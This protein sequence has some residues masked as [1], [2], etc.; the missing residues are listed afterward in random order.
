VILLFD[1]RPKAWFLAS[2][3][4]VWYTAKD[5]RGPYE[6]TKKVPKAVK[7]LAPNGNKKR[8]NVEG[9]PPRI[10]VATEPT[11]LI[12]VGGNPEYSPLGEVDLLTLT[13][14]D[15][16]VI[17]EMASQKHYVLLSGRWFASEKELEGPWN[18]VA[19]S[20]LPSAFAQI[21]ADSDRGH[22]LAH[23]P[24][25]V[26]AQEALLDN[27]IPQTA[28]IRRDD[29]SFNAEY[30]GSPKF[31][32]VEG[33]SIDYA[34][35]TPQA[36]FK[37]GDRY[38][39]CDQGVW[40]E[41]GSPTGPWSVATEVPKTLYDIPPSNPHHN[42]TYVKV[43][44]VTPQV[45]HVGYTPGYSGSYVYQGCVVYGTGWIYPGWYGSVYYP[46]HSTWGFNLNYSPWYGWGFG[47]SWSSG[48]LTVSVGWGGLMWGHPAWWGPWGWYPYYPPV[49]PPYFPGYRPPYYPG[50]YPPRYPGYR[51]P[52]AHLPARNPQPGTPAQLPSG[53][54]RP[55][56][57][58]ARDGNARRNAALPES[59]GLA[60]PAP[61][62]GRPDNVLVDRSGNIY[63]RTQGGGW[64]QRQGGS[65][66][67]TTGV[68]S[69]S[70]PATR[71]A[72]PGSAGG[73]N[74][75][76]SA[77]QRGANRSSVAPRPTPQPRAVPRR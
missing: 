17:V 47:I 75:D 32:H 62:P 42:V 26:Q 54:S 67:G 59:P 68:G 73:V 11:E 29:H 70:A 60:R 8:E 40:Y 16:D 25:T 13:N 30:D 74:R 37:V 14:A 50:Y 64:E 18:F 2:G 61:A 48:P 57:L 69:P 20:D 39:A 56:N 44:D 38:Y 41:S 19:P 6:A 1:P 45:V 27:S 12:V 33:V 21:P 76:W 46:R 7:A 53:V 35:N 65:W 58:Y 3:G 31:E 66:R 34:V 10:I 63:R 49:Y 9:R 52:P 23:V 55:A 36:V 72:R 51:P 22:V 77:R 71:P 24:G 43:Y 5:V 15:R 4:D 28:A